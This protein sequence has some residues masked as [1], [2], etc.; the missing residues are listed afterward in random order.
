MGEQWEGGVMNTQNMPTWACFGC[1]MWGGG[2]GDIEHETQECV[3]VFNVKGGVM[4]AS[5]TKNVS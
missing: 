3:F 2:G 5:N 1:S 4:V